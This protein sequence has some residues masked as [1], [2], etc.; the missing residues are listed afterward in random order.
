MLI[1]AK[2]TQS[3]KGRWQNYLN[4]SPAVFLCVEQTQSPRKVGP[5]ALGSA[6]AV[7][8]SAAPPCTG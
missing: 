4:V 2:L 7:L 3:I 6:A 8:E 5:G 1:S